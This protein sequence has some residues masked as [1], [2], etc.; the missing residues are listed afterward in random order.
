MNY[1]LGFL[2]NPEAT[3]VLLME[4]RRPAWQAGRLNGIGGKLEGD[5]TGVEA[6]EREC[7]EETGLAVSDWTAMG[8]IAFEGGTV[9]VFRGMAD[10]SLARSTTDEQVRVVKLDEAIEGL[11]P[12][13]DSVQ[14]ALVA[15]KAELA[16][17][18]APSKSAGSISVK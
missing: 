2:T 17:A 9:F 3:H 13:V 1:C 8:S 15:L 11:Y 10:L 4:K 12:L 5:E 14:E 6:M 18:H 7:L 16:E